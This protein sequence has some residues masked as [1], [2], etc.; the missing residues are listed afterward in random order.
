MSKF[1]CRE[2]KWIKP[3]PV[4]PACPDCGGRCSAITMSP[5][6]EV[7]NLCNTIA[8]H[9]QDEAR[10]KPHLPMM[11]DYEVFDDGTKKLLGWHPKSAT[12]SSCVIKDHK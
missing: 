2:M 9:P 11:A 3:G 12:S 6:V 4:H 7:C 1:E 10:W 8:L 5:G